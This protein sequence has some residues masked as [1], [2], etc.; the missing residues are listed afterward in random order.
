MGNGKQNPNLRVK[1]QRDVFERVE[2][3]RTEILKTYKKCEALKADLKSVGFETECFLI[4][5]G[6][7]DFLFRI[8]Q[9]QLMMMNKLEKAD[10]DKQ[11]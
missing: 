3:V 2:N 6:F 5:S 9:L 7:L 8:N 11:S 10:T 4:E 1:S